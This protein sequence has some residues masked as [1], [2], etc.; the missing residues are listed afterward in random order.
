MFDAG[1]KTAPPLT[2]AGTFSF[3]YCAFKSEF[4]II[5]PSFLVHADMNSFLSVQRPIYGTTEFQWH[6]PKDC[7]R[8]HQKLSHKII[9]ALS[10]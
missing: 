5:L 9:N 6:Q 8:K 4:F 3:A 1:A 2:L 10:K 7:S